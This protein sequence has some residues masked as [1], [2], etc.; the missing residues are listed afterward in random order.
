MRAAR[1]FWWFKSLY[2]QLSKGEPEPKSTWMA[3]KVPFSGGK[4]STPQGSGN[5]AAHLHDGMLP[6]TE[7]NNQADYVVNG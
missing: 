3:N 5:G 7:N 2:S 1:T 4:R 6:T